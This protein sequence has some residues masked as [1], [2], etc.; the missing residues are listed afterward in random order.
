[1]SEP[2]DLPSDD[3]APPMDDW[4]DR[5]GPIYWP[6]NPRWPGWQKNSN[7]EWMKRALRA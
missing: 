2:I 6:Q 4:T 7:F 3:Y 1:M 5:D